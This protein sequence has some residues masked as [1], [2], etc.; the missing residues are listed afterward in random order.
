LDFALKIIEPL[1]KEWLLEKKKTMDHHQMHWPLQSILKIYQRRKRKSV[2]C[3]TREENM[4]KE[5][6]DP[7]QYVQ[8][9]RRVYMKSAYLSI[10]MLSAVFCRKVQC[11]EVCCG[12]KFPT[13]IFHL[14]LIQLCDFC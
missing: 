8:S 1:G 5:K 9:V 3:A 10:G 4:G 14:K 11:I 13:S 7:E 2:I 6:E 12:E